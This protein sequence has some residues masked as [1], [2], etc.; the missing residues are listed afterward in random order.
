MLDAAAEEFG[1][2][3]YVVTDDREWTYAE[4]R[5][6][7]MRVAA[8]LQ[9]AGVRP[10]DHVALVMANFPEFVPVKFGISR[11]GAVCVPIN[12]LNRREELA[13]V[14][15]QSDAVLLITMDRFRNLEYLEMLDQLAPGWERGGGGERLPRLRGVVVAS[16]GDGEVRAGATALRE[17]T[18]SGGNPAPVPVDPGAT[19]D[20]LYTSGTTGQ[21]KGV[22]LTH[23]M[24]LRTAYGSAHGRAFE[25]G[26]RIAF[27]LPMYH[28]FG[29]V[30]G[31]LA[32]LFVGGAIIP[33]T[34]FSAPDTLRAIERH[35]ATD[36]LLVPTMTLAVLDELEQNPSGHDISSL[37]AVISSGGVQPHGIWDR[38]DRLLGQAELTHGYGMTETTASATVT[39]P[40]EAMDRFRTTNGRL[41]D[42][43]VAGDPALGG[44]LVVYRVVDPQTGKEVSPGVRGELRCRGLGVTSGYY[45]K[46]E[47]TAA[48][49]DAQ[50]WFRTGDLGTV[51]G[52]GYVTLAG[53]LKETYRCG[54]EQ[55]MP[56]EV[57]DVLAAHP[58]VAEAHVV[59]LR[60]ERMGEVGVAWIV[61]RTGANVSPED[62]IAYSAERLA[63]FKVPRH[64]LAIE[65]E[66][67]PVTPS[68]RPR[69]FLLAEMAA[70]HLQPPR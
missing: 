3:P 55:V 50:G 35:R 23:D 10:G 30:E 53:R 60:D 33:Q 34:A 66:R 54:G 27:A 12:F 52:A 49:F 24:L 21:P 8:G 51:D 4:I 28:V 13:Y 64:V 62:L 47:E 14:L 17:L 41:R 22:L 61:P 38:V 44:R 7:S 67:I 5:D 42:V 31:L 58:A 45:R 43:G 59:P 32:T 65:R 48:A 25:D 39:P 56:R 11:A 20:I 37:T 18:A 19:A 2:R 68:G 9:Q 69:K 57:E 40:G 1:D 15:G 16:T 36:V 6:W 26:R 46:P 70:A 63:A 29:Y